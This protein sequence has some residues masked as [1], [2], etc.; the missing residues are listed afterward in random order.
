MGLS[1]GLRTA[2]GHTKA[3]SFTQPSWNSMIL[4]SAVTRPEIT[5]NPQVPLNKRRESSSQPWIWLPDKTPTIFR[6]PPEL[7]AIWIK[8]GDH[9]L[10]EMTVRI[11]SI[12]EGIL[13]VTYETFFVLLK[14][15]NNQQLL[16]LSTGQ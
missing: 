8:R 3:A 1:Y 7:Q 10:N 11:E 2:P 6:L 15:Q 9:V 5:A 13:G 14:Q 4:H 16:I 12:V